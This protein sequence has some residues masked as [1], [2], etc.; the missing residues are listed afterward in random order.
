ME[1]FLGSVAFALFVTAQLLAVIAVQ[2]AQTD[3]RRG[4]SWF[5]PNDHRT[6]NA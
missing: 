4:Q 3:H 5:E 1:T 2:A 6:G